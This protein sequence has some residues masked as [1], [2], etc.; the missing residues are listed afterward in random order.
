MDSLILSVVV[1]SKMVEKMKEVQTMERFELAETFE[2]K[3]AIVQ[4][5]EKFAYEVADEIFKPNEE[6][7][8]DGIIAKDEFIQELVAHQYDFF[9]LPMPSP[10]E[11]RSRHGYAGEEE[12]SIDGV[13]FL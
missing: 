12:I 11:V 13:F 4:E 5:T 7:G 3:V 10:E 9:E 8:A 2:E 6:I 1:G